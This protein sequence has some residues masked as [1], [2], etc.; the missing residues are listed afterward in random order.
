METN[1]TEE[2]QIEAVKQWWKENGS[3]IITGLL[4]GIA[5]LFGARS[6]F[7]Y[8]ERTAENA[9]NVYIN[10]MSA[11][12][13]DNE[14]LVNQQAAVLIADYSSTPYATLAALALAKIRLEQ[15]EP[16]AART[17]LQWALDNSGAD[18]LR[19]VVRLRLVRVLIA[20]GDLDGAEALLGQAPPDTAFGPLHNELRGD[21]YAA[22]GAA[23]RARD[24]YEH[25]LVLMQATT[26]ER[27][28]LQLKYE[29][30]HPGATS[31]ESP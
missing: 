17:Q 14:A 16:E 26:P 22:R 6:W 2:Q 28:I 9:S 27:N 12:R 30:T 15:G 29:N 7:A 4:L 25:A 23:E 21:I 13:E 18:M 3:S 1:Q 5:L 24:E 10:M 8:Q 19:E 20:A 31:G 11:L